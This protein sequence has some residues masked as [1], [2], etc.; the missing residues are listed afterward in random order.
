MTLKNCAKLDGIAEKSATRHRLG[1]MGTNYLIVSNMNEIPH[2]ENP[3]M[4]Y[5]RQE[6]VFY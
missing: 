4:V 1:K 5:Y 6:I 3:V 2:T